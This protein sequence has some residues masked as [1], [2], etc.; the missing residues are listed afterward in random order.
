MV[1]RGLYNPTPC[2]HTEAVPPRH[3]GVLTEKQ[4]RFVAEYAKDSNGTQA[5]IRTGYSP[6]TANRKAY[7]LLHQPLIQAA[8][9]AQ[10][11]KILEHVTVDAA[12]IMVEAGRIAVAIPEDPVKYPD[13]LR[14]LELLA[15]LHGMLKDQPPPAQ[16]NLDPATLAK[17]STE[18][19]QTALT[20]AQTVQDLLAGKKPDK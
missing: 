7:E 13:K 18:D 6:R 17:M 12:R 15:K 14:A 10:A 19:L 16:W 1:E 4:K 5:A 2:W 3:V 20:H 8:V 11:A 9:A